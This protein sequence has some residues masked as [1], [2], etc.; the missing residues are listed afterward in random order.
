MT[1]RQK[2][3]GQHFLRD[4][5]KFIAQDL[6]RLKASREHSQSFLHASS[7]TDAAVIDQDSRILFL[8][9]DGKITLK[10]S[11]TRFQ[12]KIS[13]T[14]VYEGTLSWRKEVIRDML[15][16]NLMLL[17]YAVLGSFRYLRFTVRIRYAVLNPNVEATI[18]HGPAFIRSHIVL[19]R[20]SLLID[21]PGRHSGHIFPFG[22]HSVHSKHREPG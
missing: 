18:Y 1:V 19:Q 2:C 14:Q 7:R 8:G 6:N 5:N 17:S 12:N 13:E 11:H 22:P 4:A 10:K 21:W 15:P 3:A 20:M 16:K 9:R